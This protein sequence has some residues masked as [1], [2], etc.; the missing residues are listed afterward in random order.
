MN[1]LQSGAVGAIENDRVNNRKLVMATAAPEFYATEI[2]ARLGFDAVIATRH[3]IAPG[4][5]ICNTIDGDNCYGSEKR[6]RIETW[7][8][9]QGI[10]RD[11]VHIRFYTD[12]ISDTPTLN[13]AD[14]GYAANPGDA[15][16][17]AAEK[18]GWTILNFRDRLGN[19]ALN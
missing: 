8:A 15:F 3:I 10:A 2:G 11:Q 1:D 12:D 17:K 5:M 14:K 9:E 4:G 6:R 19:F 16:A 7:M 13:L 18:S